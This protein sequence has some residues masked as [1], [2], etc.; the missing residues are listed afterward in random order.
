MTLWAVFMGIA[1]LF[2]IILLIAVV[3]DGILDIFDV[4]G[5]GVLSMTSIGGAGVGFGAGGALAIGAVDADMTMAIIAG[6]VGAV[7][8]GYAA[9]KTTQLF[10]G[11]E[12]TSPDPQS[13][14]GQTGQALSSAQAGDAFEFS[15]LYRGMRDKVYAIAPVDVSQGDTLE[16][17]AVLSSSTLRVKPVDAGSSASNGAGG[18][19]TGEAKSITDGGEVPS[20]DE[21]IRRELDNITSS[22]NTE[23]RDTDRQNTD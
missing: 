16:V 14:V 19:N 2:S 7:L 8:L 20:A 11:M 21:Q 9:V 22:V 5:D 15:V 13:K 6:A 10:R 3:F 17:E 1:A 12:D 4:G 23:R 18:E